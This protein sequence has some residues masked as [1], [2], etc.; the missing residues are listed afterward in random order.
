MTK[1][2]K[3]SIANKKK[4]EKPKTGCG[5]KQPVVVRHNVPS[6]VNNLS[7]QNVAKFQTG[8]MN[9]GPPTMQLS[10]KRGIGSGILNPSQRQTEFIALNRFDDHFK[11]NNQII[12]D[13]L[14]AREMLQTLASEVQYLNKERENLRR[15]TENSEQ[16]LKRTNDYLS[17]PQVKDEG[18]KIKLSEIKDVQ[19]PETAFLKILS[20]SKD[21]EEVKDTKEYSGMKTPTR[22]INYD[23]VEEN[24][25]DTDKVLEMSPPIVRYNPNL[26]QNTFELN[27]DGITLEE[28]EKLKKANEARIKNIEDRF[29]NTE[30]MLKQSISELTCGEGKDHF[31]LKLKKDVVHVPINSLAE[32]NADMLNFDTNQSEPDQTNFSIS[33]RLMYEL[34]FEKYLKK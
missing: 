2:L 17:P 20:P 27:L 33:K 30:N 12:T 24:F 25:K 1:P 11:S 8:V 5:I 34:K 22:K 7:Q 15:V 16:A 13:Q 3:K 23:D 9:S 26:V 19:P 32:L 29:M 21:N 14:K 10:H 18:I 4:E 6:K 31:L 28:L